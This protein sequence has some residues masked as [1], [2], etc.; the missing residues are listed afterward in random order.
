MRG[1]AE[2]PP[3]RCDVAGMRPQDT[4]TRAER[5]RKFWQGL[6]LAR[7][8]TEIPRWTRDPV[9]GVDEYK[10]R[11]PGN[12][13][14]ALRS[15]ADEL[16]VSFGSV[17]LTAHAKVLGTLSGEGEVTTGY[18]AIKGHSPLLCRVTTEPR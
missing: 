8:F 6:L 11:I 18:V 3:G 12:L 4:G 5:G 1:G 14:A 16:G 9:A 10:V 2:T 13:E 17:L 7:P 15:L